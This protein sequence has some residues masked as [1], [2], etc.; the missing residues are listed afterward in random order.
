MIAITPD[1][2]NPTSSLTPKVNTAEKLSNDQ[3]EGIISKT[4]FIGLVAISKI[5]SVKIVEGQGTP[6]V[7]LWG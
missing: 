2:I 5:P 4:I 7:G 1:I 6:K 3:M